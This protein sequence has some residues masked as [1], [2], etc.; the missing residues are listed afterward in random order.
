ML[1]SELKTQ[2]QE[3]T[4]K[5]SVL[6]LGLTLKGTEEFT[7]TDLKAA[8]LKQRNCKGTLQSE[9]TEIGFIQKLDSIHPDLNQDKGFLSSSSY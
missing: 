5:F 6:G 4:T 9:V 7:A 3:Q 1:R 2:A 8:T